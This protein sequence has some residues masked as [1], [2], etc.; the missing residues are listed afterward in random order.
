MKLSKNLKLLI[1]GCILIFLCFWGIISLEKS[2]EEIFFQQELK[3]NPRLLIAETNQAELQKRINSL[4]PI[5]NKEADDL[6]IYAKSAISILINKE[7]EKRIL[8]EKN[9]NEQLPIASLT[10]LMTARVVL[11]NYD[12]SKQIKIS[13]TAVEQEEDFGKLLVDD[14]LSVRELLYPLLMESSNDAAFSLANDYDGMNEKEFVGLMNVEAQKLGL[15]NTRFVNATGLDPEEG[16]PEEKINYSTASDLTLLAQSLL[17]V[18]LLWEIL[19]TSEISLYGQKLTNTN[20]LLTEVPGVMGGKTGYTDKALG[21][22]ILTTKAPKDKGY[23]I[24]VVLGTGDRFGQMEKLIN[25]LQKSYQ[26]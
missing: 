10:K 13:K 12:L 6:I 25:W 1:A 4:K 21:C 20:Q 18:P 3:N 9:I 11:N 23:L 22:F 17:N 7:G 5:K 15:K 26:W 24:N 8:F 2:L 19:S 16:E 14:V